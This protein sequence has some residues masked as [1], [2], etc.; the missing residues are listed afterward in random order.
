MDNRSEFVALFLENRIQRVFKYASEAVREGV[1][2]VVPLFMLAPFTASELEIVI[3]GSNFISVLDWR[4][5]STYNIFNA[6]EN[7]I[8]WFWEAVE[9]MDDLLRQKLL[10]FVTACSRAPLLGFKALRPPF[11][12]SLSNND[13]TALPTASTCFNLFKMPRY[14]SKLELVEKVTLAITSGAGFD[15]S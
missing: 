8:N 9:E 3:S 10:L 15:M 12:I 5:Y 6:D 13:H 14:T 2:E 1:A 4:E 7:C 11:C